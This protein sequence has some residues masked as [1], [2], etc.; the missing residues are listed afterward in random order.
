MCPLNTAVVHAPAFSMSVQK[1]SL[2]GINLA[3]EIVDQASCLRRH[4]P[5]CMHGL[6]LFCC[7]LFSLQSVRIL[8]V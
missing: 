1:G 4:L 6:M 8:Y 2:K 5:G 7:A 3:A